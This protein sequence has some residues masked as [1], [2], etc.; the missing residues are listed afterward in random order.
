MAYQRG[1]LLQFWKPDLT[2]R[3]GAQSAMDAAK[4]CFLL[5]A[6]FR[7]VIYGIA[8]LFGAAGGFAQ[9]FTTGGSVT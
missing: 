8:F 7:V 4:F 3:P 6:G 5:V 2:T 9:E 1:G